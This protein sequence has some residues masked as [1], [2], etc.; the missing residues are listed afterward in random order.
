MIFLVAIP[1][2]VKVFNWVGILYKGSIDIHVHD[3]HFVTGHLHYTMFGGT[4]MFIWT[5]LDAR[6]LS[7]YYWLVAHGAM[8]RW[9]T[10]AP[11]RNRNEDVKTW[12]SWTDCFIVD[13]QRR[14]Q[15]LA[16]MTHVGAVA[17]RS[18][19]TATTKTTGSTSPTP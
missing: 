17:A 5:V 14:P 6:L 9:V 2:G 18:T 8:V 1:S 3:T 16:A 10:L 19:R 13:G 12:G 7:R 15:T 4:L 11:T